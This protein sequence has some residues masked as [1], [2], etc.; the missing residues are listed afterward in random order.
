[1]KDKKQLIISAAIKCF[2]QKGFHATSIQE[3]V[4]TAGIAKGSVY[5]YF[6]SK[7]DLLFVAI[8]HEYDRMMSGVL[9]VANDINLTPRERLAAQFQH[10]LQVTLEYSDFIATLKNET[11]LMVND[12]MKAFLNDMHKADFQW[13]CQSILA[14]YG[15][16]AKPYVFD[17]AIIIQAVVKHFTYMDRVQLE[18]TELTRFFMDRLDDLVDGMI[19]KQQKPI[20]NKEQSENNANPCSPDTS[21]SYEDS[22]KAV[23]SIRVYIK[24]S[25]LE[26]KIKTASLSYLTVLDHEITKDQIDP[27]I[28]TA[29]ISHLKSLGLAEI[30]IN[31]NNLEHYALNQ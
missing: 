20:L 13:Y 28:T 14:I 5:S 18:S 3:I 6:K 12:Q 17:A 25:K 24:Q 9:S 4:D 7:E 8:K 23:Q 26:T 29:M 31:L 21:F 27:I 15:D 19:R 16:D 2:A 10:M 22:L 11:D 30:L 1:M